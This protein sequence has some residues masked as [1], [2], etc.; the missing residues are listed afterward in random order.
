MGKT[1]KY[2]LMAGALIALA[3]AC[4]PPATRTD[5]IKPQVL[6]VDVTPAEVTPGQTFVVSAYVTDA[7]GATAVGFT[8]RRNGAPA[9]FCSTNAFLVSGTT[10]SGTWQRTCTAPAL[11]NAGSYQ[12]NTVVADAAGNIKVIGDGPVSPTSGHFTVLGD[13][14]DLVAPTVVSVDVTPSP[15]AR[16]EQITISARLTDDTGV[17]AVG[18]TLRRSGT[19]PNWCVGGATLV[20]GTAIDGIWTKTCTIGANAVLGAY[21]VNTAYGDTLNN[22]GFIGD[23]PPSAVTGDFTVA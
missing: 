15:A 23:G 13:V 3:A 21:S 1:V 19:S 11:L 5:T 6:S 8:A 17:S 9:G 7:V 4:A 14:N 18:F 2:L 12:F 16:G 22:L 10:K 20:E